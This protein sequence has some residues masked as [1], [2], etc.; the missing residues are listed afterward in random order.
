MKEPFCFLLQSDFEAF[1]DSGHTESGRVWNVQPNAEVVSL[2]L[3]ED[4]RIVEKELARALR[5][6]EAAKLAYSWGCTTGLRGV[7]EEWETGR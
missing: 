2:Y 1:R 5:V 4:I 3:E 6:V 7:L